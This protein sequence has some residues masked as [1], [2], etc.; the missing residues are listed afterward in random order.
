[1]EE[2]DDRIEEETQDH[3]EFGDDVELESELEAIV[4]AH[5]NAKKKVT[6]S[7]FLRPGKKPGRPWPKESSIGD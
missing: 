3:V 2:L 1:M 6:Q 4:G 5:W 7:K